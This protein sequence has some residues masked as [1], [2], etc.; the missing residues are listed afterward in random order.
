MV[1]CY[2]CSEE[3][4]LENCVSCEN[5]V[6]KQHAGHLKNYVSLE[7]RKGRGCS[8]CIEDGQAR[9]D[10]GVTDFHLVIPDAFRRFEHKFYPR[11]LTDITTLTDQTK[12]ETFEEARVLVKELE[13]SIQRT[14]EALTKDL[15]GSANRIVAETLDKVQV[16]LQSLTGEITNAITHQRVEVTSDAEKI[17]QE[18]GR[19]TNQ[20]IIEV[21]KAINTALLR[22]A[23]VLVVG[24]GSVATL[25]AVVFK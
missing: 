6:C 10:Y 3:K 18:I 23:I 19:T 11:M 24:L 20:A 2:Q 8:V 9:P 15:E 5:P 14:S 4:G 1:T 22:A 25:I 16:T 17:V 21:S 12:Q 13:E 7:G